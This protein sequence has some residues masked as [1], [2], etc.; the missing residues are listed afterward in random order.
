[1]IRCDYI[2]FLSGSITSQ[3]SRS[4]YIVNGKWACPGR[5]YEFMSVGN[6]SDGEGNRDWQV[7]WPTGLA[8][9]NGFHARRNFCFFHIVFSSSFVNYVMFTYSGYCVSHYRC[10]LSCAC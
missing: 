5:A 1:M 10:V 4:V 6:L 7:F 9:G 2:R 8:T 3:W